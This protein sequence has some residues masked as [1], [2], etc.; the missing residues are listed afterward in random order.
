MQDLVHSILH[1]LLTTFHFNNEPRYGYEHVTVRHKDTVTV[2]SLNHFDF[3]ES[4]YILLLSD[5]SSVTVKIEANFSEQP[6]EEVYAS[7]ELAHNPDEHPVL[8]EPRCVNGAGEWQYFVEHCI[9]PSIQAARQ[10]IEDELRS[11]S[12]ADTES[13]DSTTF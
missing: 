8:V 9:V 3:H 10:R 11:E 1:D 2:W 4:T 5:I 6:I 12:E 13:Q 7:L